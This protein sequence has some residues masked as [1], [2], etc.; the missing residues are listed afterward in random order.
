MAVLEGH[1]DLV[2]RFPRYAPAT[3][4]E[5]L[6]ESDPPFVLDV[7]SAAERDAGQIEESVHIPL[8]RLADHLDELPRD[9]PM[10]VY[11]EGGF[12]S[13]IAASLLEQQGFAQVSDLAGGFGAWRQ[14]VAA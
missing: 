8:Q 12:R 10:V 4:A 14:T 7:R 3:L 6:Q 2:A 1:D 13:A 5:V 9:R 11:C